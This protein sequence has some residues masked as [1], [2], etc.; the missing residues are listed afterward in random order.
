M[1][2]DEPVSLLSRAISFG[3]QDTYFLQKALQK[4]ESEDTGA[5]ARQKSSNSGRMTDGLDFTSAYTVYH[6][7]ADFFSHT[8][9]LFQT[10]G[11]NK[12]VI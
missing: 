11:L 10:M 4:K 1:Q 2:R 7:F 6:Y 3:E 12:Y 8:Q 5:P 9:R